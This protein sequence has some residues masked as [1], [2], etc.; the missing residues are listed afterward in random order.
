MAQ[1]GAYRLP[2]NWAP[3]LARA[4]ATL[5]P[6]KLKAMLLPALVASDEALRRLGWEPCYTV[7]AA[8]AGVI[9]RDN[10][11]HPYKLWFY[12]SDFAAAS[13]IASAMTDPDRKDFCGLSSSEVQTM[14][15]ELKFLRLKRE[16]EK[17]PF[18]DIIGHK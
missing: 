6:F 12:Q 1:P 9:A 17:T 3:P 14:I 11:E 10:A 2:M 7:P 4:A 16:R 18:G 15:S 5:L 13:F 8:L